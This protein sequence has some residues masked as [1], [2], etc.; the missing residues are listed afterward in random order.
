MF[1]T[2]VTATGSPQARGA[3][4]GVTPTLAALAEEMLRERS[5]P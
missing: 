3:I 1:D 5:T 4:R 2:V